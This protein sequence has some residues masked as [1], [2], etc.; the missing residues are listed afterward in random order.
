MPKV[1]VRTTEK[2]SWSSDSMEKAIQLIDGGSSIRNAAK[3]MGIP[4]SSLQK[5]VKKGS[6]LGPHL[7]RFTVFSPEAEAELAN[8]VEVNIKHQEGGTNEVDCDTVEG[9][10]Y[11]L[12]ERETLHY[13]I[14]DEPQ[15][16]CSKQ[17]AEPSSPQPLEV[18]NVQEL[19]DL[20]NI[21]IE[22][23]E[24]SDEEHSK[25]PEN[26]WATYTPAS[27]KEPIHPALNIS[28]T[29][30]KRKYTTNT[31]N[32]VKTHGEFVNA[33]KEVADLQKK[34]FLKLTEIQVQEEKNK[35]EQHEWARAEHKI[36]MEI[37]RE[38]LRQLKEKQ[39]N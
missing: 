28:K 32:I 38:E 21:V 14:L 37:L 27:L 7:G 3:V 31:K 15:A 12:S 22:Y 34:Y 26:N 29:P 18:E 39:H 9:T 33:K 6:A 19:L 30:A 23:H 16:A 17:P 4:F 20:E 5:R 2:A 1:R 13:L 8:L 10:Y 25:V 11:C 24:E 36:R 35:K